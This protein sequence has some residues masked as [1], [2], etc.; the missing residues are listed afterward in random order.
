[1][2]VLELVLFFLAV[3]AQYISSQNLV[4][5][6]NIAG[7]QGLWRNDHSSVAGDFGSG[8]V[9]SQHAGSFVSVVPTTNPLAPLTFPNNNQYK[10]TDSIN[11]FPTSYHGIAGGVVLPKRFITG[12]Q[13]IPDKTSKYGGYFLLGGYVGAGWQGDVALSNQIYVSD[14]KLISWYTDHSLT[15][16]QTGTSTNIL[17]MPFKANQGF[18]AVVYNENIIIC[19]GHNGTNILTPV[20]AQG[21]ISGA[22]WASQSPRFTVSSNA[23]SF[24]DGFDPSDANN[25]NSVHW[26]K[27]Y[28]SGADLTS[29]PTYEDNIMARYDAAGAVVVVGTQGAARYTQDKAKGAVVAYL[30]ITGGSTRYHFVSNEVVR[31][32]FLDTPSDSFPAGAITSPNRVSVTQLSNAPWVARAAHAA[33][34]YRQFL[35]IAGGYTMSAET[36][37]SANFH[38]YFPGIYTSQVQAS[39]FNPVALNDMWYSVDA[40]KTWALSNSNCPWKGRF[41]HNLVASEAAIYII[42]GVSTNGYNGNLVGYNDVWQTYD[43]GNSW[44]QIPLSGSFSPRFSAMAWL[45]ATGSTGGSEI[46]LMGGIDVGGGAILSSDVFI[47]GA[48]AGYPLDNGVPVYVLPLA[49]TQASTS[50]NLLPVYGVVLL[51]IGLVAL[52]IFCVACAACR[53]KGTFYEKAA[54]LKNRFKPVKRKKFNKAAVSGPTNVVSSLDEGGNANYTSTG[55]SFVDK[56]KPVATVS[57]QSSM[58]AIS[59]LNSDDPATEMAGMGSSSQIDEGN[60]AMIGNYHY[61][62]KIDSSSTYGSPAERNLATTY[63]QSTQLAAPTAYGSSSTPTYSA[64]SN[65]SPRSTQGSQY[66]PNIQQYGASNNN[67]AAAGSYGNYNANL[68]NLNNLTPNPANQYMANL[69]RSNSASNV[70]NQQANVNQQQNYGQNTQ[71]QS[72]QQNQQNYQGYGQSNYGGNNYY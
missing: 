65:Y 39:Y 31:M 33:I 17:G 12:T 67:S 46:A 51:V 45:V 35:I 43:F 14:N 1:M 60:T 30:V 9:H 61:T 49:L 24:P 37:S 16:I 29:D 41:Y 69:S 11:P 32:A 22:C 2:R 8:Y 47:L 72:Q 13:A 44:A 68:A 59:R 66:P 5:G 42:A 55:G 3:H 71:Q 48:G 38:P 62:G 7:L 10:T 15:A 34:N 27:I 19:G 54:A 52:C 23:N 36:H 57:A 28:P 25:L 40:G 20:T 64:Q 53:G 18:V 63:G 70:N 21:K 58:G 4:V 50:T 26:Q 6:G 56:A